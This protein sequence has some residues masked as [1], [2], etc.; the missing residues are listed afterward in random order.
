MRIPQSRSV[1]NRVKKFTTAQKLILDDHV[2]QIIDNPGIGTQKKGDLKDVLVYK[3]Q[4][5]TTQYLLA[6][7]V[8]SET[9][10]LLMIGPHQNYY[11]DLK[12]HLENR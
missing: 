10:E 6:Y 4:I 7:R 2:K 12:R 5:E 9:L 8:S 3:F 1:A 11:R